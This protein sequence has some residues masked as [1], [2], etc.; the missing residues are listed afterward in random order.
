MTKLRQNVMDEGKWNVIEGEGSV[1]QG[2][3][4][5]IEGKES[6]IEGKGK[7]IEFKRNKIV[8]HWKSVTLNRVET[9]LSDLKKGFAEFG[10][11]LASLA[12]NLDIVK[13]ESAAVTWGVDNLETLLVSLHPFS[14]YL[15][16]LM[17]CSHHDAAIDFFSMSLNSLKSVIKDCIVGSIIL[18]ILYII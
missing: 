9:S 10:S 2:K 1:T 6:L 14:T 8:M 15:K 4:S 11:R 16:T 7:I 13:N 5:L 3:E 18:L 12:D 17:L